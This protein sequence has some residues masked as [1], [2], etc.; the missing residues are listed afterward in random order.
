MNAAII[1]AAFALGAL[2]TVSEPAHCDQI[3][4]NWVYNDDGGL[5]LKQVIFWRWDARVGWAAEGWRR[6]Q[7]PAT[8]RRTSNGWRYEAPGISVEAPSVLRSWTQFDR[9]AANRA[10]W[11]VERRQLSTDLR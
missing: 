8:L 10:E 4:L 3:E 6:W 5:W 2:P 1:Y 7:E 11:P 9:E